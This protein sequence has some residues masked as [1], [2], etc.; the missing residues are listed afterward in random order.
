MTLVL[1][2][3]LNLNLVGLVQN[4]GLSRAATLLSL[5]LRLQA[6]YACFGGGRAT[7]DA[8]ADG[9]VVVVAYVDVVVVGVVAARP[10]CAQ[11]CCSTAV[12]AVGGACVPV[13]AGASARGAVA[14]GAF[15]SAVAAA[16]IAHG[17]LD[18]GDAV[19]VVVD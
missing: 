15:A 7:D 17:H 11:G 13:A 14:G 18:D 12:G 9:V 4:L 19:I 2:T 6:Y 1:A 3:V 10:S 5:F 16:Q 8:D